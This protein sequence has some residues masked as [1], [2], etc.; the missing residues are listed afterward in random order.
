MP[1]AKRL[2]RR[3]VDCDQTPQNESEWRLKTEHDIV[4]RFGLQDNLVMLLHRAHC[5]LLTT[6]WRK[7]FE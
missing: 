3:A 6:D 5:L 7:M 4:A 1:Q 2:G